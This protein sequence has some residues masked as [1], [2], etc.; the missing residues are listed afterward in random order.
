MKPVGAGGFGR[1]RQERLKA[2][3]KLEAEWRE[4]YANIIREAMALENVLHN[5]V[6]ECTRLAFGPKKTDSGS[7]AFVRAVFA[8]IEGGLYSLKRIALYVGTQQN[9]FTTSEL[10]LLEEKSYDIDEKGVVRQ[11]PKYIQLLNNV[12]FSFAAHARVYH[13]SFKINTQD[14]GWF[15]LVEA[16]K[17]RHRITHPKKTEELTVSAQ[18]LKW[19]KEAAEFYARSRMQLSKTMLKRKK[20]LEK[21]FLDMHQPFKRRE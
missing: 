7:R 15:A 20:R 8:F 1:Q 18:E 11:S 14:P 3:K 9:L 12:K 17:V 2:Q 19:A 4:A 10:A 21:L 6:K 5:D 13:L 16:L